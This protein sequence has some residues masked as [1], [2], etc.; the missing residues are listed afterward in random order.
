MK[1]IFIFVLQ[2]CQRNKLSTC[3]IEQ[4]YKIYS[5]QAE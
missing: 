5:Q 4:Y 3:S 2:V 1:F